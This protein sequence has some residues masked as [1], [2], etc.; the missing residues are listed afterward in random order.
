MFKNQLVKWSKSK[1]Y[2][3]E[4]TQVE[5]GRYHLY[6]ELVKQNQHKNL[7]EDVDASY[8]DEEFDFNEI[9]GVTGD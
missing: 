4:Q 8:N 5:I 1:A 3:N 2:K 9:Y 7:C 6:K